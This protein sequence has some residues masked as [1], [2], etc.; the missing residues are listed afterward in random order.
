MAG[1]GSLGLYS[2][3]WPHGPDF[4]FGAGV[5]SRSSQV[6]ESREGPCGPGVRRGLAVAGPGW[7]RLFA[8]LPRGPCVSAGARSRSALGQVCV[9]G[10]ERAESV[11][12]LPP[13][14]RGLLTGE[15]AEDLSAAK[16]SSVLSGRK[17]QS[18]PGVPPGAA[19]R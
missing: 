8:G 3:G 15:S 17:F 6:T 10:C 16:Y 9:A 13:P 18:H 2:A 19:N 5:R 11:Q 4:L 7:L 14:G 12:R 1:P